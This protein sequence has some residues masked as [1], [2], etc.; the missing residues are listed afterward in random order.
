LAAVIRGTDV[1]MVLSG[2][3]HRVSVGT[4]GG[5]PVWVSP[6]TASTADVLART[7]FRGHA[8]GGFT[9]VDVLEGGDVVA[10]Y[11]PLTGR[12]EILYDITVEDAAPTGEP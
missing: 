8:G 10:T 9:R 4:L 2:H 12:D 11:V 6:A 1:R 5:V 7:G 3:T